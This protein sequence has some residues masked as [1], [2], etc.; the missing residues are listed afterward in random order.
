[1]TAERFKL[2]SAVHVFLLDGERVLLLRRYNTG[3][4]DGQYGVIAGHLDGGETVEAAAMREALEEVGV[5]LDPAALSVVGV[6][7]RREDDER[8]DWFL[9]A[10]KWAGEPQN[11]E[12]SKCDELRWA[13]LDDLPD[14]VIPYVRRALANFRHGRWYDSCGWGDTEC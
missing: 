12:P 7:H 4:A 11:G 1:M 2:V 13:A 8:I 5:R 3:Y 6:M 9:S 10:R 14:H